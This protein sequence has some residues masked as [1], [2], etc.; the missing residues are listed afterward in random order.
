MLPSVYLVGAIKEQVSKTVGEQKPVV[1]AND[2]CFL[3]E[4]TSTS[5]PV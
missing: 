2:F 4:D 5:K 1:P 3:K